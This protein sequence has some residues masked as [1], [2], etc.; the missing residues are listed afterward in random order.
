MDT[1]SIS[2]TWVAVHLA[3]CTL[4]L[5][6]LEFCFGTDYLVHLLTING[7]YTAKYA[8][9]FS[10]NF[11]FMGLFVCPTMYIVYSYYTLY[12]F[13][14]FY[15]TLNGAEQIFKKTALTYGTRRRTNDR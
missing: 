10:I 4:H 7:E 15:L 1:V 2:Q 6:Q 11:T 13:F 9:S 3:D 5:A 12:F 14:I 8:T